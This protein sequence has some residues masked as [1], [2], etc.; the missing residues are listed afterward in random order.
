MPIKATTRLLT[1]TFI[2]QETWLEEA[3]RRI[4]QQTLQQFRVNGF[5]RSL[6]S[7]STTRA[8]K[9][10]RLAVKSGA[11]MRTIEGNYF[12]VKPHFF[13]AKGLSQQPVSLQD[14][15]IPSQ[16]GSHCSLPAMF[17]SQ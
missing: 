12:F 3:A 1:F 17:S 8:A 11:T 13:P 5:R 14:E 6:A 2:S 9:T 7:L 4:L 10:N 15:N 16:A